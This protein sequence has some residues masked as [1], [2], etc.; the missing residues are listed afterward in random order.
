MKA[1]HQFRI[2]DASQDRQPEIQSTLVRDFFSKDCRGRPTTAAD[3]G[4]SFPSPATFAF[5]KIRFKTEVCTC[6]QFPTE[7][8]LW[9]DG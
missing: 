9:I 5:W 8:L 3:F 7:A 2:R 4:S 6:S 1:K